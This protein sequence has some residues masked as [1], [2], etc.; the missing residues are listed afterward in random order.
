MSAEPLLRPRS[1]ERDLA[2]F[3]NAD[4]PGRH[5]VFDDFLSE[6]AFHRVREELLS[7]WEWHYRAQP[8]YVLC[9]ELRQAGMALAVAQEVEL[10]MQ[11]FDSS[12]AICERWAFLHQRPFDKFV[13]TDVGSYV[14]TVWLTSEQ[15]DRS[16]ETSGI[17]LYSLA[18]PSGMD[19]VREETSRYFEAMRPAVARYVPYRENRAV[20]FPASTFHAIGPCDFDVSTTGR[21][22][23]SMTVILDS[24]DHW[25]DQHRSN[26]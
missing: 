2:P 10:H 22:R 21:M 26:E 9:Q 18:R 16:P 13:H 14:L 15:W 11:A 17:T 19:N 23:C 3:F 24:P 20:V 12:L 6:P 1:W 8:G 4:A 25:G 7:S 5:I